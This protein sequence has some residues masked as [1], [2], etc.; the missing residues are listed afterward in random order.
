M[1]KVR[2]PT[3]IEVLHKELL[4]VIN[5]YNTGLI[6]DIELLLYCQPLQEIYA[7]MDLSGLYDGNGIRYD[8]NPFNTKE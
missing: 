7:K 4:S 6:T 5:Q 2:K 8:T 1:T 3:H